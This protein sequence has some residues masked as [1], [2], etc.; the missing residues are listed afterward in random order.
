MSD[1]TTMKMHRNISQDTRYQKF[2]RRLSKRSGLTS[3]LASEHVVVK[4]VEGKTVCKLMF[5][6]DRNQHHYYH[7][8]AKLDFE[9]HIRSKLYQWLTGFYNKKPDVAYFTDMSRNSS[10]ENRQRMQPWLESRINSKDIDGLEWINKDEKIFKVPWKHVGN[11]EWKEKDGIIFREWAIH[12][13]RFREGVDQPDWP[14]WKTR[15][16]CALTKLP[17]IEELKEFNRLDGQTD[18]PYRVYQFVARN[19]PG[20][21]SIAF[22]PPVEG[23][24]LDDSD[25]SSQHSQHSAMECS[26]SSAPPSQ[27]IPSTVLLCERDTDV[28]FTDRL[29]SDIQNMDS[30]DLISGLDSDVLR[31]LSLE[32]GGESFKMRVD[33]ADFTQHIANKP[34]PGQNN[35][36]VKFLDLLNSLELDI[37][38]KKL[39][40]TLKYLLVTVYEELCCNPYGCRI[41]YN[42][43]VQVTNKTDYEHFFGPTELKQIPL[44]NIDIQNTTQQKLTY[45]LLK[46]TE[47]GV[48]ITV[49]NGNIYATRK[50]RCRIYVSHPTLDNE[51]VIIKLE[52]DVET[53]VFDLL[54]YFK[55]ALFRYLHEKGPKPFTQVIVGFGQSFTMEHQ[56]LTNL[57]VSA[58]VAHME[59]QN[60]LTKIL[61]SSPAPEIEHSESTNTDRLLEVI[62]FD[63]Q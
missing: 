17:G 11:R 26:I 8:V 55:P 20:R 63:Q 48:I 1:Q 60:V 12:T 9:R 31:N 30:N 27:I 43:P 46:A 41:F 54:N 59:A 33:S 5:E 50:C 6:M 49:K 3:P 35:N 16:R 34:F 25:S 4:E 38:D 23:Q 51:C 21:E 36:V 13:G 44:P 10:H 57:L 62:G 47:R 61:C 58:S 32:S 42:K 45:D 14:T 39:C 19:S 22:S 53:L 28:E 2:R 40:I 24:Y 52:R 18:E 29:P 15:F 7:S 37:N 56:S